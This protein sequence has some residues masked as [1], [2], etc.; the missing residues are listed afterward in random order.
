MRHLGVRLQD[1]PGW[2]E[3]REP[4]VIMEE[5]LSYVSNEGDCTA[6]NPL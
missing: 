5:V 1:L 3:P 2:C 4:K 6:S